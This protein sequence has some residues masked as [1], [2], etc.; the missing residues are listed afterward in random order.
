M[1]LSVPA[2]L[3][4]GVLV[5]AGSPSPYGRIVHASDMHIARAS[6]AQILLPDGRV[7]IAGG[8]SGSGGESAPYRSTEFFD[9]RSGAFSDGP[10]LTAGRSTL[11]ATLLRDGR[12]LLAGGYPAR[13]GPRGVAELFDPASD[14]IT[15]TGHMVV[16]RAG[17]TATLLNDGRVLM[18]G[19]RDQAQNAL[20]SA[21]LYDP[22]TGTFTLTGSMSVP[23]AAHTATLL[24]DGRVLI[25]GGGMGR[26][27]NEHLQ[28][29]LEVFDP[30]SGRFSAAGHLLTPRHKHAAALLGD[31]RVLIAGGS[32]NR[33]WG[34]QFASTEICDISAARCTPGPG[35]RDH[36]FKLPG[37]VTVLPD[38]DVLI[39]GGGA[40]A[41]LLTANGARFATVPGTLGAARY[42]AAATRLAD[43]RVLI[44]GGYAQA[45]R[46]LPASRE[47]HLYE[48]TR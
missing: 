4:A 7:F 19:G 5:S 13:G 23:R 25:A 48:P 29:V 9:P 16:P 15:L 17:Q 43:G 42:F 36:R 27:P 20:A 12:V 26:Y 38:G 1:R 11:T 21:E 28:A 32:D 34:G 3:A 47:A 14:A 2:L 35:M 22:R 8:F 10:A 30:A 6:H 41:E 45:H 33:D 24:A 18:T 39:A 44:T 40:D 37:A 31:G 46:G